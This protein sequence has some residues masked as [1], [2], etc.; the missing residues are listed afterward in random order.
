ML[1]ILLLLLL[2]YLSIAS[3]VGD[4]VW[5]DSNQD[6]EQDQGE[7]GLANI[8][9]NLYNAKHKKIK[10]TKTDKNGNYKFENIE[11]KRYFI[12]VVVPRGYKAITPKR[13]EF[14]EEENLDYLDFGLNKLPTASG[15]VWNDKDKDWEQ[16]NL[17]KGLANITIELFDENDKKIANTK[18]DKN[19]KYHFNDIEDKHYLVQ[20]LL[21]KGYEYV[22]PKILSFW[23][24]EA[25]TNLNFGIFKKITP[26]NPNEPITREQLD[27]MIANGEDVTKVNTS[28]I[29]DMS[30]LFY[31][32]HTFNQD[33][34]GWDT[35]NVTNMSQMFQDNYKFNQP[36]GS[37]DVSKVTD[38]SRL[39]KS[40]YAFYSFYSAFNQDI[41]KWDTSSVTNM[42]EMF[43]HAK[44][45]NQ[46]IG[47]WDV[48]KVTNMSRLFKSCSAFNQDLSKWDTSNVVNMN[49]MFARAEKFNQPIGSWDVSKVRNMSQMFSGYINESVHLYT[50]SFNQDLSTWDVS[51][52]ETMYKMFY[53][54]YMNKDLTKWNVSKVTSWKN[55]FS[56]MYRSKLWKK[57]EEK[58]I[59]TKFLT[60]TASE[61]PGEKERL[62]GSYSKPPLDLSIPITRARLIEMIANNQDVTKVNTSKIKDMSELFDGNNNFNQDISNW[63]TSNVTDMSYMFHDA[64]KFNQDIG[65]WDV[66]NVTNMESMFAGYF[67]RGIYTIIRLNKFNRDISKWDVSNVTNMTKM[68]AISNF[69]QNIRNWYVSNVTK[70]LRIFASTLR[71]SPNN[72]IMKKENSPEKLFD[73]KGEI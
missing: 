4:R 51:N 58:N 37:W 49:E 45:F 6:W 20:I 1:M 15:T 47:S 57:M 23:E 7:Q 22:T 8:K 11:D 26:P 39:F 53:G 29:T 5:L 10:S 21:P 44:N 63:D 60:D 28:K 71:G 31:K 25:V 46:P 14:W 48:S 30:K 65:K 73:L 41:S 52:V 64:N 56:L 34:S 50:T 61:E 72:G 24:D 66:S 16:N 55:I 9:I 69:N 67:Y 40:D 59:P 70:W 43:A 3:T 18:T 12:K 2:P 42:S 27:I 17:E 19:G 33:I 54:S 35:S 62:Y 68:F 38:M 36:I 32:N 13:F